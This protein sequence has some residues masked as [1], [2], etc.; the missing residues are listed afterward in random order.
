[1]SRKNIT[2]H[3]STH[4]YLQ[5]IHDHLALSFPDPLSSPLFTYNA[6]N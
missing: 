5:R 2:E 3:C 1:M 6:K 4:T